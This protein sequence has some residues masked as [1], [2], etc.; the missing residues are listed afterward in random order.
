VLQPFLE[1]SPERSESFTTSSGTPIERLYTPE[2]LEALQY[3][4]DLGYPGQFPYTRGVYPTMYRGR[5][6]TMRQYAGFG[7]AAESNRRYRYLLE[8]GQ[9]GLSVAFDLC[10]QIGYDSDHSLAKGEVGKVGVAISTIEDM[11]TLLDGIPL[12]KVSTSMTINSTAGILLAMV[13]VVARRRGVPWKAL[14]GTV[15]NDILKEYIARGT[16]I[17]PPAPSM[18]LITDIFAFCAHEVPDWNPISISGY[19]I[20]EAGSTAAQEVAFTLADGIAYVE[21]ALAA[22]LDV[23]RFAGRLSFFFN[24]HNDLLE[25]VAKFR[26]AR[27]LWARIMRERFGARKPASMQLRF[28]AQTSGVSLTA[29]QPENNVI[30]VTVQA[31][32]AVLGGAQ[33][34]HTNSMDEALALPTE[35]SARIALRTQQV[36]AHESGVA[37]TIDALGGSYAVESLTKRLEGEAQALIQ[38]VDDLGGMV[39]AIEAG[40]VQREIQEAAY[41]L[42]REIEAG[43][44]V[45]V[46]VNR[47]QEERKTRIPIHRVDPQ[48]EAQQVE[49]L[50]A[51]RARRDASAVAEALDAVRRAA[52]GNDAIMPRVVDAVDRGGTLGEI[53]DALRTVFG[54]YRADV[55]V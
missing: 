35:D 55:T 53:S 30:R 10:T 8:R 23:D 2:D 20:R 47:F 1:K 41:T 33:S 15:Q 43:S 17:Y 51:F 31:L 49:R 22:G 28:H 3:D 38:R 52:Q 27:R 6:W 13:L 54:E 12:D 50:G 7:T 26:A 48:L 29:Q 34:L 16:Y 18:R 40:F 21:A 36:L 4:G 5:L 32:A 25:E 44:R 39:Q 19:H 37:N 24:A 45:V 42:Q 46:G 11:E 9:T 14:R